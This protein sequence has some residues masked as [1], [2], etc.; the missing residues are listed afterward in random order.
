MSSTQTSLTASTIHP[1]LY[2]INTRCWLWQLRERHGTEITLANIPE[3][4]V[5]HWR[6]LGFTHIWLM[7]VWRIGPQSRACSLR[8][9]EL[10]DDFTRVLP[11]L[12]DEDFICSTYAIAVYETCQE[13]GGNE[14]LNKF[15]Q[16]LNGA[17]L[18]LILDFIPN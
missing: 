17:G 7:G 18:K 3:E 14:G 11:D 4:E 1:L 12:S 16:R 6:E 13:F 8:L 5:A 10:R 15:R 9:E 2:E